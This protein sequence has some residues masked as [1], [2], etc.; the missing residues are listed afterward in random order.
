[1]RE[2]CN[3]HH[4]YTSIMRDKMRKKVLEITL[5]EFICKLWWKIRIWSPTNQQDFWLSQTCNFF[6]KLFC[7]PLV[8]CIIGTCLNQL[9]VQ[10]T[11]VHSLI[12]SHSKLNHGHDQR[13]VEGQQE[14][15][16]SPA[17]GWEDWIYNRQAAW[18]EK[19]TV[20]A[21]VRKW[22][23]YKTTDNLPRSGVKLIIRMVSK[24]PRTT[25]SDLMNDLQRAG[26]KKNKQ[27]LP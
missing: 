11:P 19:S 23:T 26:T 10:N 9:S 21:I 7:P 13:A 4:R 8:T 16:C 24:N 17:P 20:G 6:K 5:K 12:Q 3:F 22:K 18:C 2:V 27:S 25:R 1:M 14:E 15:N